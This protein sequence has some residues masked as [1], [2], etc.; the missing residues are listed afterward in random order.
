MDGTCRFP[1]PIEM[2]LHLKNNAAVA[3]H[4]FKNA[5]SV[6]QTVIVDADFGVFFVKQLAVDINLQGH[7]VRREQKCT[8]RGKGQRTDQRLSTTTI[9]P[10]GLSISKNPAHAT[11]HPPTDA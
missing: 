3:S 10:G 6:Q 4:A 9:V 1:Q 5:I 11:R 8:A 7:I 2:L